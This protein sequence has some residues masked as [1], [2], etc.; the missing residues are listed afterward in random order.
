MTESSWLKG[1]EVCNAGL[2]KRMDELIESGLSQRKAAQS[3][4]DE[5]KET[6]GAVVY[7]AGAL[8]GR[9]LLHTGKRDPH[10]DKAVHSEPSP[11]KSAKSKPKAEDKSKR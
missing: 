5:Q 1:C 3:L 6:L 11:K 9:Y 4:E 10:P 8:R 7:S 2:C